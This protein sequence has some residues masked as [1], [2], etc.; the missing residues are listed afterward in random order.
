M[1]RPA[2]ADAPALAGVA[3]R[4]RGRLGAQGH[5]PA[6]RA[7]AAG[8][9]CRRA[10]GQAALPGAVLARLHRVRSVAVRCGLTSTVARA[11]ERRQC[12]P[13]GRFLESALWRSPGRPVCRRACVP[14]VAARAPLCLG[15]CVFMRLHSRKGKRAA[16]F[17]LELIVGPACIRSPA[18]REPRSARR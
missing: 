15:S 5:A 13:A 2:G 18:P 9:R 6:V 8:A 11:L 3:V 14:A 16:T 17:P 10:P 1:R 12:M 4:A 7:P